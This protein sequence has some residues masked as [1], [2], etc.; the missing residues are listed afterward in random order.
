[1]LKAILISCVLA[2][3]ASSAAAE[4]PPSEAA[5]APA[6]SQAATPSIDPPPEAGTQKPADT[7]RETDFKLDLSAP[8]APLVISTDR[9]GFSTGTG[10]VPQWHP[11]LENG[12]TFTTDHTEGVRTNNEVGPQMLLRVGIVQDLLEFRVSWSGYSW[13]QTRGS[14]SGNE[15]FDG[16]TDVVFGAKLK[17]INQ[18]GWIPRIAILAQTTIGG[19]E[20]PVATQEVEP[21]VGLLWSYDLGSGW[22][23]VG[24]ANLAF[25]TT[26]G[27][28]FTQGQASVA[29]WF[30]IVDKMSGFVET[31]A[32]FPN[33]KHN[34]AA[35]YIDFGA[36]Y[37]LNDRVQLDASLGVGLNKEANDFYASVGISFL[38]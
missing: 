1:M 8:P 23:V 31:Y 34:D 25:P 30:P 33:S 37:L 7:T 22:S 2:M 10:I 20:E 36:T 32:L 6:T 13:V 21:L 11:Q 15:Y 38:F 28:H 18:D 14:E 24:N 27:E 5:A 17:A 16:W 12:F 35:Y 4:P 9:P 19:G 29:L 26:G 3:P